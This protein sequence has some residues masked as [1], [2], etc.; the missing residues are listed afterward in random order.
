[1]ELGQMQFRAIAFVL[2]EA[3]LRKTGAEVT[4][5]R[6]SRYLGDH[7]GGGDAQADAIAIY[8]CSLGNRER[9]NRQSVDQNV[10]GWSGERLDCRPHRFVRGSQNID[11]VDLG[12]VDDTNGPRDF[13]IA[14]QAVVDFLAQ[15]RRKL[16]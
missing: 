9:E 5:H 3:I 4:H 13:R 6:V 16:F 7:A 8:D 12:V 1:M 10:V 14:D 11:L 2:A 15:F